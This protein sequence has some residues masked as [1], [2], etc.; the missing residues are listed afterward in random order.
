M[1]GGSRPATEVVVEGGA[2]LRRATEA[3]LTDVEAMER[4]CFASDPWP[5][6]SFEAFLERSSAEF[7][8]A[9]HPDGSGG[10]AGYA[11]VIHA[12]DEAELLNIAVVDRLRGRG[13]GSAL[14]LRVLQ[15]C[16][17]RSIRAVYLEVRES[18]AAARRLYAAHG[19]IEVGRRRSYYER[20]VED[21][22]ILQKSGL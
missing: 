12:A 11:V 14:L 2:V 9:E 5:R 15:A 4:S 13:L 22:L 18:N 16:R 8:V 7:V 19:F 17:D 10:V 20:P 21:A 1:G 6:R 3:D